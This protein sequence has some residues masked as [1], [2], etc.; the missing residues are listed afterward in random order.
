MVIQMGTLVKIDYQMETEAVVL[1]RVTMDLHQWW[2][3]TEWTFVLELK[4]LKL[5]PIYILQLELIREKKNEGLILKRQARE[6]QQVKDQIW[7]FKAISHIGRTDV[8]L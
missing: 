2:S 3:S 5:A 1:E 4:I 7:C 8:K 6:M